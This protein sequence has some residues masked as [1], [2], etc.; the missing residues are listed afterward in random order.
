MHINVPNHS[1]H[2]VRGNLCDGKVG[3]HALDG[4]GEVGDLVGA[5]LTSSDDG[6]EVVKGAVD[7]AWVWK[8]S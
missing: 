1:T 2:G 7:A 4:G 6:A 8:E 5:D 3:N